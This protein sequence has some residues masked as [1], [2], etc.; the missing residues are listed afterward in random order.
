MSKPTFQDIR[1]DPAL[2]LATWFGCGLSPIMPGTVGSIGALPFAFLIHVT[3]GNFG[4]MAFS[5]LM[6]FIGCW[7]SNRYLARY[8]ENPDPGAIVIDEVAG[9]A[10]L[11]SVL[12]PT[13]NSYLV[14][15]LL[16]RLFDI[17]KPWPVSVADEKIKGGL[18]VMADDMVAGFY[19]IFVMLVIMIIAYL[20]G[21]QQLLTHIF[22]VLGG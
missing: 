21:T 3:L 7:A 2:M 15:L 11:L 22:A 6:F 12:F 19:P 13:F 1:K 20:T 10:L 8:S 17:V 16:F 9:Q 18:G 5:L 14:G 4:L